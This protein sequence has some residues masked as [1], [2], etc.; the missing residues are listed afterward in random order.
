MMTRHTYSFLSLLCIVFLLTACAASNYGAA[1]VNKKIDEAITF[2]GFIQQNIPTSTFTLYALLRPAQPSGSLQVTTPAQQLS[3]S[4][5]QTQNHNQLPYTHTQENVQTQASSQVHNHDTLHVYIEGDGQAWLT[6][7]QPSSDPTPT[8]TTTLNIAQNDPTS[9]PVLYLARPC[10]YV[11][12]SPPCDMK[13][14]T[15]HRFAPEVITA[16]NE[17]ISIVKS[18]VGAKKVVIVGYSGGGAVAALVAAQRKAL[19]DVTFLGSIAGNLDLKTWVD[20]HKISPLTGSLDPIDIAPQLR[21]IPQ[22]HMTSHN[23]SIIPP[24]TNTTFC[25]ALQKPH[26]CISIK[27]IKHDGPWEKAWNYLY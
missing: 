14:W 8:Q 3:Q 2:R 17:A 20:W 23:D 21:H 7:Y 15:S 11:H 22:R 4:Y 24:Q 12:N 5:A 13:Y 25:Q 18:Q 1:F 10:Q 19:G 16:T 9:G 27:D 26:Y 6:R